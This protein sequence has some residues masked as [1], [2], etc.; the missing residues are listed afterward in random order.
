M[1]EKDYQTILS[2]STNNG[3]FLTYGEKLLTTEWKA[4]RNKILLRDGE[5]CCECKAPHK[6]VEGKGIREQTN[7]EKDVYWKKISQLQLP[8]FITKERIIY[9][10]VNVILHVHHKYYILNKLPWEYENNALI[11]LCDL[12]HKKIHET[13][14]IPIYLDES[15]STI[16]ELNLCNNCNGIGYLSQYKYYQNGICFKCYGT[17]YLDLK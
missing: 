8:N 7:E 4:K 10:K 14:I 9:P 6:R 3:S 12:C 13:Q 15:K 11:T 17:G 2:E 5:K 1:E 16:L